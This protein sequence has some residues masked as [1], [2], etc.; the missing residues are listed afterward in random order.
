M[1]SD[2]RI[3]TFELNHTSSYRGNGNPRIAAVRMNSDHM[4]Q[5][6]STETTTIT[7]IYIYI[8]R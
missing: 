8:Y 3:P 1:R 5:A 2:V 7:Y 4:K 6:L